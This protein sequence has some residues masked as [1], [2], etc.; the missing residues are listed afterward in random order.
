MAFHL[1]FFGGLD[2]ES[3]GRLERIGR[4]RPYRPGEIIY[5]QNES[6]SHVRVIVDGSVKM[7]ARSGVRETLLEIRTS[8]DLLG[9]RE[10]LRSLGLSAWVRSALVSGG[11]HEATGAQLPPAGRSMAPKARAAT[12]TALR[13]TRALVIG[14]P[15]FGRFLASEPAA[16]AAM[17]RDLEERL[18][19]AES[20]LG[21]IA[22]E[23]A[24]RRLAR[25]LLSLSMSTAL[26][27]VGRT[28]LRLSQ[29]EL[30]S[31]VGV[32]RETVERLLRDWRRRQIIETGY[33]SI[34]VLQLDDL[35]RIAGM[36]RAVRPPPASVRSRTHQDDQVRPA[37]RR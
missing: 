4:I 23:G 31:W 9:E 6:S 18:S 12:A 2:P 19:E 11:G 37:A 25:A 8:G 17:V 33:R 34:T 29:A 5:S 10:V 3:Q 22:S 13:G 20:R 27:G 24:N 30:A 35:M 28:S 15:E 16:W 1:G 26:T 14:G 7:T 21:G 32:S 36:R